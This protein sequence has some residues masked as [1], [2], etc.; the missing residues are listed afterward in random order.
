[1]KSGI[2][3]RNAWALGIATSCLLTV[4]I[5]ACVFYQ[6]L[7]AGNYW[8]TNSH[9]AIEGLRQIS[10]DLQEIE[11]ASLGY[12]TTKDRSFLFQY[13]ASNTKLG[14]DIENVRSLAYGNA[15]IEQ[16]LQ[17]LAI[18]AQAQSKVIA[19]IIN[20]Q[21]GKEALSNGNL[22]LLGEMRRLL[23]N[24]HAD[25]A[26]L[27]NS[28]QNL[29]LV[30]LKDLH[31]AQRVI[32]VVIVLFF[33]LTFVSLITVFITTRAYAIAQEEGRAL[34][35]QAVADRTR[36]LA[37]V[38]EVLK[39][40][41]ENLTARVK[42]RT[43]A[44]E[45]SNQQLQIARDK[46]LESAQLKS[47][48]VATISHELRTPMSGVLGMA[49]LLL[50]SKL[51]PQAREF[52]ERIYACA[53]QLLTVLNDLLDFSKLEVGKVRLEKSEFS[54][55]LLVAN[56]TKT[57]E[58]IAQ[59][60]KLYLKTTIAAD[61]PRIVVGDQGRNRQILLNLVH[62]GLKFTDEGGVLIS[63][64][65]VEQ[66]ERTA[67]I[68]FTVSDT[69]IGISTAT[70]DQ[71]FQPFVQADGSTTRIYG[72]TGLGLSISKDLVQL[73]SGTI[74]VTSE[75]GQGSQFWYEVPFFLEPSI[76]EVP[77]TRP[78]ANSQARV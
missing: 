71:L 30:R 4:A 68:R 52:A 75:E 46:A 28:Q 49:E 73:M 51:D 54:I 39:R 34:L 6:R 56:V 29:R 31:R 78:H 76:D 40:S 27:M 21:N 59:H 50:D 41:E 13:G 14:D 53:N 24:S 45:Q 60:K 20:S 12:I 43:F 19:Q 32:L 67:R 5:F 7:V 18:D 64:T 47:Q 15:E 9:H 69:G 44:L 36:E 23:A 63:V 57:V 33:V 1:M 8:L 38:N 61:V 42:E 10:G 25:V 16:S 72:G 74:G 22:H 65:V 70:Q 35:E 77:V 62:N 66:S 11:I 58:P 2:V 26:T 55:A 37:S 3:N 17:K 48:F